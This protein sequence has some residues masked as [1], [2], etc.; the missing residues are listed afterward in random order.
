MYFILFSVI[1]MHK[2]TRFKGQPLSID[3]VI[4]TIYQ[5]NNTG[6]LQFI[7]RGDVCIY[8]TKISKN[9]VQSRGRQVL[10]SCDERYGSVLDTHYSRSESWLCDFPN[11]DYDHRDAVLRKT[12]L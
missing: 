12:G 3:G 5:F 9:L 2:L 7:W 4:G 8:A 1:M 6:T 10:E 11:A